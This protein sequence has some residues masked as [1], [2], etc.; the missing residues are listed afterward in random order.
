ME[1]YEDTDMD[2]EMFD[3][4]DDESVDVVQAANII[5]PMSLY[6]LDFTRNDL[7]PR[8]SVRAM[9][10]EYNSKIR[11]QTEH[12]GLDVNGE[13]DVE[14]YKQTK[15]A[16]RST[17]LYHGTTKYTTKVTNF[18]TVYYT[19]D[20]NVYVQT[21]G[22]AW[23]VVD[24]Y[25]DTLFPDKIARRLLDVNGMKSHARLPL[26]GNTTF[27]QKRCKDPERSYQSG[28][29]N[30]RLRFTANLRSDASIRDTQLNCFVKHDQ[31][32]VVKVGFKC[33][34][35]ECGIKKDGMKNFIN[36][37]NAINN[38]AHTY[39]ANGRRENDTTAFDEPTRKAN[40]SETK[41][42][43]EQLILCME[44]YIHRKEAFVEHLSGLDLCQRSVEMFSH[45]HNFK[46]S[47]KRKKIVCKEV[48]TLKVVLEEI[49]RSTP[50]TIV[51]GRTS[52]GYLTDKV[53][54]MYEKHNRP[55]SKSLFNLIEGT[56]MHCDQLCY[57]IDKSWYYMSGDHIR[58]IHIN[59]RC[60]LRDHLITDG[61]ILE[62]RWKR[63]R[64]EGE[65]NDDH[66]NQSDFL[67][68][69]D[70]NYGSV[71]LF[72]LLRYD[73]QSEQTYLYYVKKGMNASIRTLAFQV[74]A[75]TD[76][77]DKCFT[78]NTVANLQE[79]YAS[80]ARRYA[81]KGCSL[82]SYFDTFEKFRKLL[83]RKNNLTIV[84]AIYEPSSQDNLFSK[85]RDAIDHFG[86]VNIR[87]AYEKLCPTEKLQI[88]NYFHS[89]NLQISDLLFQILIEKGYVS[90]SD[91][92]VRS[93]GY[94]TSKLL[95]AWHNHYDDSHMKTNFFKICEP[96]NKHVNGLIWKLIRPFSS[97]FTSTSAKCCL[98]HMHTN[99]YKFKICEINGTND[100]RRQ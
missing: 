76:I 44:S 71:E 91:A 3:D 97:Y 38:Q 50:T 41:I 42:L 100:R 30:I 80:I 65:Y 26:S 21:T 13:G 39:L 40:V 54:I 35:F 10:D 99:G 49:Q 69:D 25:S 86:P 59:F 55:M 9:I 36:H 17:S 72:D 7:S 62:K 81:D 18:I 53:K 84:C 70:C 5:Q 88:C 94:V 8:D 1:Y 31:K 34:Q 48:P 4:D 32:I 93:D 85:E 98:T 75:A 43:D 52:N 82:S 20:G 16:Q 96:Y 37:L 45:A 83:S 64:I 61:P 47:I 66:M 22:T 56:M 19:D 23:R 95:L 78:T 60:F 74:M 63:G 51:C 33:V 87:E 58:S 89:N 73:R 77:L 6:K 67:V 15:Y 28:T 14:T 57:R 29:Q 92:N 2:H 79:C 11:Q 24:N 68:G 27:Q 12:Y 46:I 90:P